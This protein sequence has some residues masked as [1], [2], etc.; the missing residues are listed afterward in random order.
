MN[1]FEEII[2]AASSGQ[3]DLEIAEQLDREIIAKLVRMYLNRD[4]RNKTRTIERTVTPTNILS[5][6]KNNT[7]GLSSQSGSIVSRISPIA[8]LERLSQE[9]FPGYKGRLVTW[10]EATVR[11][12]EARIDSLKI[13]INGFEET[14]SRHEAAIEAIKNSFV[15]SYK[16]VLSFNHAK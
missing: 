8:K 9:T 6:S 5:P 13:Q 1:T 16:E 2:V 15:N 10:A 4:K 14:I 12:H 11:D 3:S 7:Q